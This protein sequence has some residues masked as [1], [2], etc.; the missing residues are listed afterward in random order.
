MQRIIDSIQEC[1]LQISDLL[2]HSDGHKDG[3]QNAS[4]DEQLAV[5]VRADIV[6]ANALKKMDCVCM[7]VSE[8]R[9]HPEY[10]HSDGVYCVA[11]DP[12]DGSSVVEC[13]FAVGSIFGIYEKEFGAQNLVGAAYI[14]YG[15][16][17]EIVVAS[18]MGVEHYRYDGHKFVLLDRIQLLTKGKINA[19]G[20]TQKDWSDSH[21][22]FVQSFFDRGY[23]LRYSGA[24]VADLHQILKKGGGI[25]SYP[26][27]TNA[28]KGK[29]RLLFELLP[30]A[31]IFEKAGGMAT[32]GKTRL[33]DL[34]IEHTHATSAAYL[35]SI[36]EM[37]TLTQFK[38]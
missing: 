22:E 38:V 11:Y 19:P 16:A 6:I 12:L 18:S 7:F 5:D 23:R 26:A 27:S 36:E 29:L 30:F 24:M 17:L 34:P 37:K 14:L 15:F 25:F 10:G 20:G 28:P 8:E 33:L 21:R 4:G 1:A 31:F 32:D 35:G 9:E 3:T 13:D 2:Q